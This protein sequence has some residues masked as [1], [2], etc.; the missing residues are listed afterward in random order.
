MTDDITQMS[1]SEIDRVQN[2]N[3]ETDP[4]PNISRPS[5]SATQLREETPET[6]QLIRSLSHVISREETSYE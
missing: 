4:T 3:G 5:E 6:K 2:P 1:E